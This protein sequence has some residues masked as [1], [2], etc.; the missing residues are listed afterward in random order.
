MFD[1]RFA[2]AIETIL[3]FAIAHATSIAGTIRHDRSDQLY[4]NLAAESQYAAVGRFDWTIPGGSGLASGT[5]INDQWVLTA[6]HVADD[7]TGTTL[8]FTVGGQTYQGVESIIDPNWT[9]DVSQA[10]DLAL[11]RLNRPVASVTAARL[12]TGTDELGQVATIVGFGQT[13]TGLTGAYLS[14]GTKRAGNN[15]IG[16]LGDVIGYS[17]HSFLADFDYPDPNATGKA[18]ALDLEYLAAPGDSGGGWFIDVGGQT[19]L[20][21]V[22]SFGYATDGDLNFG[23]GD[24]MGATRIGDY[25]SWISSIVSI[26]IPG[27]YNGDGTVNAADY[28]VWRETDG[29]PQGYNTWRASFGQAS[30]SGSGAIANVAV[31]EPTAIVLLVM[32]ALELWFCRPC[33]GGPLNSIVL[34][35]AQ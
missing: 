17:D 1:K 13:G 29:T 3:I 12:Y 18:V 25:M 7:A 2:Y 10:G 24:I 30:S 16:G 11:V 15:L 26:P 33:W 20:A 23:Y 6:A 4:L 19:Y 5:L 31:P 27:D 28:V 8:Q 22:T 14:A 35:S 9:G 21:G 32:G 34:Y